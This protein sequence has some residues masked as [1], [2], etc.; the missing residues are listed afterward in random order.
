M[1]DY[2]EALS[3]LGSLLLNKGEAEEAEGC[4]RR[5]LNLAPENAMAH[6]NLGAALLVKKATDEATACFREAVRLKPYYF[7]ALNGLGTALLAEELFQDAE[8]Y[9]QETL[10]LRP[11]YARAHNNLGMALLGLGRFEEAEASF[12]A[13]VRHDPGYAEA[14]NHL[15]KLLFEED[16]LEDAEAC[17]RKILQFKPDDIP[18][19]LNL[20]K[21]LLE[22]DNFDGALVIYE[23]ALDHSPCAVNILAAKAAALERKGDFDTAY[24]IIRPLIDQDRVSPGVAAVF[25]ELSRRYNCREEAVALLEKTIVQDDLLPES[26][27]M[28]HFVLGKLY[29]GLDI[30][31][32]AF[33]NYAEGNALRPT[34]FD[35]E[36]VAANFDRLL[37]HFN[38]DRLARLPRARNDSELPVFI[39][40]MPR[41]GTSLVEQILANH[42][43]VFGA[44][45]LRHIER[46]GKSL[47]LTP[48]AE[49]GDCAQLSDPEQKVLD[50]A[51]ESHLERLRALGGDALRVTDKMPYNFMHLPLI[52]ML[53]PR[54]RVIHCV[55]D[56]IDTCL[57]C[58]FQN[59]ARGNFY[60]FDLLNAGLYYKLYEKVMEHWRGNLDMPLLQVRYEEHVAEP[61]QVCRE[62]LDFIGLEWDARCL[63]FHESKRVVKTASRDQVRQPI[64]TRSAGRWRHY[65]NYL[66]PLKEALGQQL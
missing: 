59:F 46:I 52:W 41:S 66:G 27:R 24:A 35:P 47:K 40:G 50:A 5:A 63:D 14:H 17:F 31:E 60:S 13:A 48:A 53:F 34:P 2:F 26:R 4:Y 1:P 37:A 23:K 58:Y 45:E 39:I 11:S 43:A 9:F 19:H 57:S 64:Y 3:N 32:D 16:R 55:R 22:Q 33:R 20:A 56:P 15:G 62:L 38:R 29:D 49:D 44:G 36:R 25:G 21:L 8:A 12:R 28:L 54:A 65:E 6:H 61:E 10:R 42:P 51:A 18:A 7:E 30:F